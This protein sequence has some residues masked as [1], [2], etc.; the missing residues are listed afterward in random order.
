MD[1]A[2]APEAGE[3][4][5]MLREQGALD[6]A[7]LVRANG[8]E[9]ASTFLATGRD[10]TVSVL[11]IS[12]GAD[13]DSAGRLR[14]LVAR[15]RRRGY[16]A[17]R[18]LASGQVGGMTFWLQERLPGTVLQGAPVP[19]WLVPEVLQLNDAQAGLGDGTS[20]LS[21]LVAATL[22]TGGDGYCVHATLEARPGTRDLLAVVRQT[23]GRCLAEIPEPGDFV[24]YDFTPA[25]LLTAGR[26]ISGVIDINPPAL[27]GDR[28]FDLATMLFYLYDQGDIRQRLRY[29]ALEL[30]NEAAL[31]AYL[32]HMLLRQ[33][34][35][36]LRHHPG[37]PDTTHHL[38][39]AR[40]VGADL[41][42]RS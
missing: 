23:A 42:D 3:L 41:A 37:T 35:W 31:D 32:A 28:A 8:G 25:N 6:L 17:A 30:S 16:P 14:E 11:K 5:L 38:H 15:L 21:E 12:P 20:L 7:A 24:H 9:S 40:L 39:L 26:G 1:Q 13:G 36:S 10:G 33:V 29:R 18:V 22:T 4:L 2:R 34:D 27:T 19:G